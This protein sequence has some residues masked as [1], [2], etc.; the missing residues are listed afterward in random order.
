MTTM[1]CNELW[2]P[3]LNLGLLALVALYVKRL[4]SNRKQFVVVLLI[5]TLIDLSITGLLLR[6]VTYVSRTNLTDSSP[7]LASLSE[8]NSERVVGL[9]SNLPMAVGTS[10][11]AGAG[12]PDVR[13]Y[14]N[15]EFRSEAM[16]LWPGLP[17]V[18]PLARW[19]DWGS[20]LGREA[21]EGVSADDVEFFRL[22]G[23]RA[24]ICGLGSNMPPP[25]GPLELKQSIQDPW[26]MEQQFGPG[27]FKMA[28]PPAGEWTFWEPPGESQSTRAWAF[29]VDAPPLPGTDPRALNRPP[30]ARRKMLETA[31]QINNVIDSGDRVVI[32]GTVKS[33][34]VLVF[35]DSHYPGWHAT[36]HQAG[37][38]Q[39][40]VTIERA[41]GRWRAVFIPQSG[42]FELE[43][44][45]KPESVEIGRTISV[46]TLLLWILCF[47]GL[48]VFEVIR[49]RDSIS[50]DKPKSIANSE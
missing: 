18:P 41:F 24:L 5:W 30:P 46:C 22:G 38:Q 42:E 33:P 7:V 13:A 17:T 19:G 14:W 8:Y 16:E 27:V 49:R 21:R 9:T 48:V 44:E 10:P 47:A 23:I 36:L 50:D 4:V 40:D 20:R 2:L 35:S 25:D 26:L 11:L 3:V 28:Q 15:E 6:R 12:T 34:S 29:P 39:P 1:L 45:C 32:R 37:K 43:F 31:E